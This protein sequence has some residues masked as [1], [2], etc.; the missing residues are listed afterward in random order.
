MCRAST[1]YYQAAYQYRATSS[2]HFTTWLSRVSRSEDSD[3]EW[4]AKVLLTRK[5]TNAIQHSVPPHLDDKISTISQCTEIA[6]KAFHPRL[7]KTT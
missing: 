3:V 5:R 7:Y 2:P 1:A 6:L 4:A